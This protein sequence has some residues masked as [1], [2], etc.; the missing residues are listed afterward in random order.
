V[1][2]VW[3]WCRDVIA[4]TGVGASALRA[5]PIAPDGKASKLGGGQHPGAVLW[6]GDRARRRGPGRAEVIRAGHVAAGF[7]AL[8]VALASW[9]AHAQ[10]LR[11]IRV[12]VLEC[13]T[14]N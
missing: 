14:V 5:L 2:H 9:T 3:H 6:R 13:G 1:E 8:V 4:G 10:D 11:T 12:G 7:A